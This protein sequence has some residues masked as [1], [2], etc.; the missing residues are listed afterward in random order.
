MDV[1]HDD[2]ISAAAHA[3]LNPR[4][5]LFS[6]GPVGPEQAGIYMKLVRGHEVLERSGNFDFDLWSILV[7]FPFRSENFLSVKK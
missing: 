5:V 6:H 1:I 3:D 4:N 2:G 7:N